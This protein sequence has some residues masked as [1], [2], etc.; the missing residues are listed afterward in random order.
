M[1]NIISNKNSFCNHGSKVS[2]SAHCTDYDALSPEIVLHQ[3]E[4]RSGKLRS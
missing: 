2:L 3:D 4:K 1:E